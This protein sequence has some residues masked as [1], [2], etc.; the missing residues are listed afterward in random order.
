MLSPHAGTGD[1]IA[2]V[3]MYVQIDVRMNVK[4]R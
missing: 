3:Q 2:N 1:L 4:E